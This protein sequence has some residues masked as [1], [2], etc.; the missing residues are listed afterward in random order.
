MLDLPTT[1]QMSGSKN[2]VLYAVVLTSLGCIWR[3]RNENIFNKNPKNSHAILGDIKSLAFLWVRTRGNLTKFKS[4]CIKVEYFS[5]S[6][7]S[8]LSRIV[9]LINIL[10]LDIS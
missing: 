5:V 2:K 4:S 10:Y 9:E 3:A 7:L 8:S 1:C 6:M